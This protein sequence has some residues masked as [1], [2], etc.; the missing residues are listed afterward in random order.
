MRCIIFISLFLSF[1]L[2]LSA[3]KK[4]TSEDKRAIKFYQKA[5]ESS[6]QR[7]IDEALSFLAKALERDNCF[8]EALL[9]SADLYSDQGET[10]KMINAYERATVIDP[11]FF[12]NASF[13]LGNAYFQDGKYQKAS[14]LYQAFLKLNKISAKNKN[15]SLYKLKCCEFAIDALKNPSEFQAIS[16]SDSINT[17]ADEYWPSLTADEQTLI[18]TRLISLGR[19][20][21][22]QKEIFQEDLCLSKKHDSIWTNSNALSKVIN[23]KRNEGAQSVT[24][25]GRYMYF[26]ASARKDGRGR[27]DIYYS[28]KV[29][30][31]WSEPV[32]CGANVNTKN[33]EA[34]PSISSDGRSLYFVSNRK[35]GKGKMDIWKSNL[36]EILEDGKQ[37]LSKAENLNINTAENEM[38]PFIHASNDYLVF[39]SDGLV[40]MGAYDLYQIDRVD[41]GTWS[42]P[43]NLSYPINTHNDEMV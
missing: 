29:G 28:K 31:L 6:R 20:G 30:D 10:K 23:T 5:Q 19:I 17:E 7:N 25:D 18:F 14:E 4:Y 41:D 9:F 24:A 12:P 36:I 37:R 15:H 1:T 8:M 3:Q 38:S 16:L 42:A 27:C 22:D 40:G 43:K 2:G 33:W 39:A 13:N 26:T 35:S 21:R 34:Q 11:N 32:N